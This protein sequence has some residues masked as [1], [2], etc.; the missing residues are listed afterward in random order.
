MEIQNDP[1]VVINEDVMAAI[2]RLCAMDP[3][4][5]KGNSKVGGVGLPQLKVMT[6]TFP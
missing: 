2:R 3:A 4:I 1:N 6:E 5:A